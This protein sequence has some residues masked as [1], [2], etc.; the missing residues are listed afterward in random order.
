MLNVP[1]HGMGNRCA[2]FHFWRLKVKV[3]GSQNPLQSD[4][5]LAYVFSNGWR[6]EHSIRPTSL[7]GLVHFGAYDPRQ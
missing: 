4:V 6:L 5:Y 7:L 3:V 2:S 1:L